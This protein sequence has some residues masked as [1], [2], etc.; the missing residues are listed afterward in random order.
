MICRHLVGAPL[1]E[2]GLNALRAKV[3]EKDGELKRYR[4]RLGRKQQLK[5][6]K[7][8]DASMGSN[9]LETTGTT[10]TKK[11]GV[12]FSF[13][14][15]FGPGKK[16]INKNEDKGTDST[17][18]RAPKEQDL[19]G[20]GMAPCLDAEGTRKSD[21]DL[22]TQKINGS[23]N[24]S[25]DQSDNET[26]Q[27]IPKRTMPRPEATNGG[28][29]PRKK[30]RVESDSLISLM[31]PPAKAETTEGDEE[32]ELKDPSEE[33][34]RLRKL[35]EEAE[36]LEVEATSL[37]RKLFGSRIVSRTDVS[38]LGTDVKSLKR[39]F[40]CGGTMVSECAAFDLIF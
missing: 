1:D 24:V 36:Q 31:A 32:E 34:D 35:L 16:P 20:N 3:R 13:N 29:I 14:S 18:N 37:R 39:V 4:A 6:A 26:S 27:S 25:P 28:Q 17:P 22:L 40:P 23:L 9:L 5:L 2:E 21:E 12:S 11:K 38:D 30:R 7:E 19:M 8:R 33:R 15:N 10:K